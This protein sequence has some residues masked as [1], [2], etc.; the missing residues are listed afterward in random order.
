M[1]LGVEGCAVTGGASRGCPSRSPTAG[2]AARDVLF[3][4]EEREV[5]GRPGG[6]MLEASSP[7]IR[8]ALA[9]AALSGTLAYAS[10]LY[11]APPEQH[12]TVLATA[13]LAPFFLT[14]ME[15]NGED[16]NLW[17]RV[18]GGSVA[19]AYRPS[20]APV[21]LG[22]GAAFEARVGTG[23]AVDFLYVPATLTVDPPVLGS[24]RLVFRFSCG[25]QWTW[26]QD[27]GASAGPSPAFGLDLGLSF[28]VS[29][30]VEI[31]ALAGG[32]AVPGGGGPRDPGVLAFP[33]RLG[34]RYAF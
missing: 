10:A 26:V 34:A 31:L 33:I 4:A 14:G 27:L 11:A 1:G 21:L 5:T 9:C 29:P 6:Q 15:A 2:P 13:E 23:S 8:R 7:C 22:A 3:R 24:L 17:S 30:H 18:G 32:R 16:Y 19:Y 20:N 28:R 12:H 25:A